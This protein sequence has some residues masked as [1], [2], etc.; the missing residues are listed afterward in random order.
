MAN[1]QLPTEVLADIELKAKYEAALSFHPI[2]SRDQN[3]ACRI[4]YRSGAQEYA[5]KLWL[6]L[7][8]LSEINKNYVAESAPD[9]SIYKEIKDIL[10]ENSKFFT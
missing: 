9:H 7:N 10:N 2:Y 8:L 5:I 6:A 4:C 3:T 1:T